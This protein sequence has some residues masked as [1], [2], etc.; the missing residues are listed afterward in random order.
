MSEMSFCTL[1]KLGFGKVN[2]FWELGTAPMAL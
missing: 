2:N 1:M